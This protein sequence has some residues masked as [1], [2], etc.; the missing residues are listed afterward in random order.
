M[1]L[2][3]LNHAHL[4]RRLAAELRASEATRMD[5]VGRL[6]LTVLRGLQKFPDDL[7]AQKV[8][9]LSYAGALMTLS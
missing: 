4:V 7:K 8:A 2:I 3:V 1:D 9:F 5:L 6:H